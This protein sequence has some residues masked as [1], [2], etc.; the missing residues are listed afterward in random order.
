MMFNLVENYLLENARL[1]GKYLL[2]NNVVYI[3]EQNTIFM[4][5]PVVKVHAKEIGFEIP[6]ENTH[7]N[8]V[9]ILIETKSQSIA[10]FIDKETGKQMV[11]YFY[12]KLYGKFH[13]IK[14]NGDNIKDVDA[15]ISVLENETI[16]NIIIHKNRIFYK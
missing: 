14:L 15:S 16:D 10:K 6:S 9:D 2:F 1:D 7:T 4:Y 11:P 5:E 12:M 3:A 8:N 13:L